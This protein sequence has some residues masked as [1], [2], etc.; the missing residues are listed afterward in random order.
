MDNRRRGVGLGLFLLTL[1]LLWI[2]MTTGVITWST[3]D[4]LLVL[5]PLVLV[6]IGVSV[7]FRR[8]ALIRAVVWLA[9][10]AVVVSYGH[11]FIERDQPGKNFAAG[12]DVRK[13]ERLAKTDRAELRIALG[14]TKIVLDSGV[15]DTGSLLEDSLQDEKGTDLSSELVEN[16]T[17][18]RI[19]FEKKKYNFSDLKTGNNGLN[20]F[21]LNRDVVWDIRVDTGA[22]D[23][24]F[25]LSSLRVE[26]MEFNMGAANARLIMGSY[27]TKLKINAGASKIDVSLP[28]DTGMKVRI[29]GGMNSDNLRED[30]WEKRDD[31]WYYSPGF[32]GREYVVEAEG[33]MGF[34]NITVDQTE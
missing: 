20:S 1:G 10:L 5:W 22:M 2:L 24:S 34:V 4:A 33:S 9:F 13:I 31:G 28:R 26:N 15:S 12:G 19:A 6:V 11:F 17:K 3:F 32:D 27:N 14:G 30:G 7:I 8:S 29:D 18:A 23:G 16:D 25:D 21:H